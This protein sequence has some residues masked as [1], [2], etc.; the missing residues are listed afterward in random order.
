MDAIEQTYMWDEEL[1]EQYIMDNKPSEKQR[2][3]IDM[4]KEE[5]QITPMEQPF[6]YIKDLQAAFDYGELK[7][8]EEYYEMLPDVRQEIQFPESN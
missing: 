1:F 4:L 3:I 8:L 7:F 5:F 6:Y 2:A